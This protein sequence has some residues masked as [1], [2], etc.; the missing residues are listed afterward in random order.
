MDVD[1]VFKMDNKVYYLS[2]GKS[3][4]DHDKKINYLNDVFGSENC[5]NDGNSYSCSNGSFS[6]AISAVGGSF[7]REITSIYYCLI[8]N[9]GVFEKVS[10]LCYDE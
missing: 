4:S 3:E 2:G 1:L 10:T 8:Y 9:T 7:V 5:Q 6:A